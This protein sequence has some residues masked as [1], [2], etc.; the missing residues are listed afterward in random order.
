MVCNRFCE[1]G[2]LLRDLRNRNF[3]K[4]YYWNKTIGSIFMHVVSTAEVISEINKQVSTATT[5]RLFAVVHICGKQF[6]VTENDLIVIQGY[7]P[8][9]PGDQLKLEKVLLVGSTDFTLVGRPILNRELV[10]IDATVVEKTFSHT[11]TR[12]RMRPRKQYK[13]IH[14]K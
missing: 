1:L 14:C 11:K 2:K 4:T 9:N 6:K 8:P 7:W 10:N 12:F 3:Q 5:S 13:R